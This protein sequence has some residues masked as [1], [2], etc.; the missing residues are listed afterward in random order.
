MSIGLTLLTI[1]HVV[2][3]LVGI[4]SG[5]VVVYGFLAAKRMEVWTTTFLVSTV[6]TS[7]TGF[8]FPFER[9]LPSHA[10]GILSLVVLTVAIVARYSLHL[11]GA[12]RRTYVITAVTAF[13]FNVFVLVAQLFQKVRALKAM[14]PTQSEP[15]FLLTQAIV[16][17]AFVVV[18]VAAAIKNRH[19]PLGTV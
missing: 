3:S 18:A 8:L 14:A 6:L 17:T 16:L 7:A 9:F 2:I 10:L 4:G 11:A 19:E 12:W 5:L 1:V 15:P 13:Y